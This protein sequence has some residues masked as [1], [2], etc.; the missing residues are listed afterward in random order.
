MSNLLNKRF[1]NDIRE[2]IKWPAQ[3]TPYT[4]RNHLT[5]GQSIAQGQATL[6]E[7]VLNAEQPVTV[8]GLSAGS[9]VVDEVMRMLLE[10]PELAPSKDNLTFIIVADSSRQKFINQ[11]K[12][13]AR[14][15]YTYQPAPIVPYD[16]IV[17]T[18]EYDGFA[19]F[20]DRPW[21]FLA[22]INAYAGVITEHVPT[23]FA[24][25]DAVPESNITVDINILGG[26]T[27]HYLVPAATLPLV[28]LMPWLKSREA[29]LKATIDK[30]YKRNDDK[31]NAA[32]SRVAVSRAAAP[33]ETADEVVAQPVE[34][35][36][37]ARTAAKVETV[38]ASV[39][40]S[41]SAQASSKSE[42]APVEAVEAKLDDDVAAVL[43]DVEAAEATTVRD[44]KASDDSA[45][46][47]GRQA[48]E[49]RSEARSAAKA[50]RVRSSAR[51]GSDS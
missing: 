30:A 44:K 42:A 36:S 6:Y 51:Q 47:S 40:D 10:N 25:L 5:L 2:D 32:A 3:A 26:K 46:K 21:N 41:D 28:K 18:G 12:Y 13:N 1:A 15:D 24:N 43:K 31:S 11:V 34:D 27:T 49:L 16:V 22:V 9:L 8:V 7:R 4:G 48:R 19:D 29:S 37:S 33:V 45:A 17:V 50:D 23:A 20:P 35:T 39:A 14:F 38:E